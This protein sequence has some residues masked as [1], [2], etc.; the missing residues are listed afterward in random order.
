VL[1]RS[2][3]AGMNTITIS[4]NGIAD[5]CQFTDTNGS[6]QQGIDLVKANP[7]NYQLFNQTQLDQ[8]IADAVKAEQLKW[9]ANGDNKI[10][11]EDIIYMLQVI[12]GI[13]P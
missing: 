5:P 6:T 3:T 8:K 9:D 13:R 1:F 7:G 10:G 11:L 4:G 2:K 12:A